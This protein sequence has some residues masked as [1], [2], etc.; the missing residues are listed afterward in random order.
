MAFNSATILSIASRPA[1][2]STIRYRALNELNSEATSM[3]VHSLFTASCSGAT[4]ASSLV[5][6]PVIVGRLPNSTTGTT[7]SRFSTVLVR[8]QPETVAPAWAV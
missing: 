3:S 6:S 1:S 7:P 8:R 4:S 2:L 5:P